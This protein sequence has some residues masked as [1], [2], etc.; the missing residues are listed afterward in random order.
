M[1]AAFSTRNSERAQLCRVER[2]VIM[3]WKNL[4]ERA[5][6]KP[7]VFL[8]MLIYFPWFFIL[9][10]VVQDRYYLIECRLDHILPFCEY[11]IV[12]YLFW[13][14]YVAGSFV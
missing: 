1:A 2:G 3:N 5:G 8:Y 9:E 6:K 13:F 7:W 12:P 11:F 14:V 10:H 4:R